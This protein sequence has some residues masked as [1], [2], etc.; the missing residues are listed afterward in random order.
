MKESTFQSKVSKPRTSR[1]HKF[2]LDGG[3]KDLTKHGGPFSN[4][5]PIDK[6]NAF[7][8]KEERLEVEQ[9]VEEVDEASGAGAV[10]GYAAP[11]AKQNKKKK[12]KKE[13][14]EMQS[15]EQIANEI[16]T[17]NLISR[18]LDLQKTKM[19]RESIKKINEM[20]RLRNVLSKL[21]LETDVEKSPHQST[22]VNVLDQVFGKIKKNIEDGYK[23]LTTEKE[24]RDSYR[25]H[26]LNA[27]DDALK[28]EEVNFKAADLRDPSESPE[29]LE[30]VEINIKNDPLD[31]PDEDKVLPNAG[32]EGGDTEEPAEE[33]SEEEEFGIEGEEL[34]GR[35]RAFPVFKQILEPI[36]TGYKS[37]HN[38]N[39]REVYHDYLLTNMKMLMDQFEDQLVGVASEPDSDSYEPDADT[40]V[41]SDSEEDALQL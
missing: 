28:A 31:V 22:A 13:D 38:P 25:R 32:D 29:E 7:L 10:A 26:L 33:K 3:R 23:M 9:G 18:M 36:T 30:E 8:A 39:D 37:L 21:I 41:S 20:F 1:A 11:L 16:K 14:I 24:Q 15:R 5:R 6:S 12:I 17:R 19:V 27:V 4:P 34:T 2:F 40:G 35:D